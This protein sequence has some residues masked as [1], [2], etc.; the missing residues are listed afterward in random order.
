MATTENDVVAYKLLYN[1]EGEA[2]GLED[3]GGKPIDILSLPS[4]PDPKERQFG[5]VDIKSESIL[6]TISPNPGA[7]C[8]WRIIRGRWVCV[9]CG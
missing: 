8:C 2:I 1:N 6:I 4:L 9:P 7:T 3:R 5:I